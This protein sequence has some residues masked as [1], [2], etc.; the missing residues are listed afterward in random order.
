MKLSYSTFSILEFSRINYII[1]VSNFIENCH[2]ATFAPVHVV[3]NL[4]KQI[5]TNVSVCF[6]KYIAKGELRR[7]YRSASSRENGGSNL[8]DCTYN[9]IANLQ[10]SMILNERSRVLFVSLGAL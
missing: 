1:I 8:W 3:K 10:P 7:A 4:W 2:R 9:E 6:R 5:F